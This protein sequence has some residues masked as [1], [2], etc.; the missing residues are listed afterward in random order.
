MLIKGLVFLVSME[1]NC[2]FS[3]FKLISW[4]VRGLGRPEKRR[5]IAKLVR[6]EKPSMVLIQESKLE[7]VG[8]SLLTQIGGGKLNK[9]EFSRSVGASGGLVSV[10]EDSFFELA[11]VVL[12]SRFVLLIGK[13]TE[14]NFDCAICNLYAPNVDGDR[15]VLWEKLLNLKLQWDVPWC[16]GGD[17]NAVRYETERRGG[18]FNVRAS[19]N[20]EFFIQSGEFVD[21]NLNGRLFT[22]SNNRAEASMARL[23]RFLISLDWI[24]KVPDMKQWS[25]QKGLS[26]HCPIVLGVESIDW[27]PTPFRF[28]NKWLEDA[29]LMEVMDG[30]W[31]FEPG[32]LNAGFR[33]KKK[34]QY[35]KGVLKRKVKEK[36]EEGTNTVSLGAQI[37]SLDLKEELQ[38]LDEEERL[39]RNRLRAELWKT[40]RFEEISWR[41]KSR[42]KWLKEGDKNTAFFHSIAMSRKRSNFLGFL[43]FNG[44]VLKEPRAIREEVKNHFK[45]HYESMGQCFFSMDNYVF[46][47]LDPETARD[48]ESDFSEEE[49]LGALE[50]CNEDRA[51]GPDGFNFGFI[52]KRWRVIKQDIMD[53]LNDFCMSGKLAKG[54]NASFIALIP[55]IQAPTVLGD[56][57]PI[58]LIGC[59]YKLLAKILANRLRSVANILVNPQQSAFV[60]GKNILDSI[61]V[62]SEVVHSMR[63]SRRGGFLFKVDFEKAYDSVNWDFLM[64][65]M[66]KM[67]FG[68]KWRGWIYECISTVTLS[69][70]VNGSPTEEFN[71]SRGL[72]QGDPLSPLLFNLVATGLSLLISKATSMDLLK[73][74]PVAEGGIAITHLQYADDTLLFCE[75]QWEQ[76][77]TFKRIL[78]CFELT[79]G[80]RMNLFKSVLIG[81]NFDDTTVGDWAVRLKCKHGSFPIKYLGFPLAANPNRV[82]TWTPMIESI[83]RKLSSWK[84]KTLSIGGRLALI[85]SVLNNMPVY[86][87]SFFLIPKS[88][89]LAI[90]RLQRQFLWGGYEDKKK[91]SWV[92]WC[93]VQNSKSKGGLGV[94]NILD[95]NRALIAKWI[96]RFGREQ[97]QLLWKDVLS[98]KYDINPES[99]IMKIRNSRSLSPFAKSLQSL[100]LGTE[101][102]STM[103]R[104]GFR[105]IIGN[106]SFIDFWEDPWVKDGSLKNLYPRIFALAQQKTGSINKFGEW[107]GGSWVWNILLRRR[108]FDWEI[109][110]WNEF[111]GLISKSVLRQASNDQVC[112]RFENNGIFMI[113]SFCLELE[114]RRGWSQFSHH[115]IWGHGAPPKVEMFGWQVLQGRV[116]VK[117]NLHSI[118]CLPQGELAC[119]FCKG[120]I[121]SVDHLFLG[122]IKSWQIWCLCLRIWD[123]KASLPKSLSEL[124]IQWDGL[125]PSLE[126]GKGWKLFFF[127]IIWSLW[128]TRNQMVFASS[129]VNWSEV[130]EIIKFRVICWFKNK[131]T[132]VC[133]S[134][135][136]MMLNIQSAISLA[137]PGKTRVLAAWEVPPIGFLKFNVDGSAH[138]KPGPTGIGGVLRDHDG[139]T[140]FL[141]AKSIGVNDSNYA[142]L[143]AIQEALEWFLSADWCKDF[144]LIIESDSKVAIKWVSSLECRCWKYAESYNKIRNMVDSI[145]VSKSVTFNHISRE[146]NY[147]A[148]HLAKSGVYRDVPFF[149]WL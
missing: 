131:S 49:I 147:F 48:L 18:P 15:A 47:R 93:K 33:I 11:H 99:L 22:W 139:N 68:V 70:L 79:S 24:Q 118:G 72:R 26:D 107:I 82:T 21:L 78:T 34:L 105:M 46:S 73:G 140:R 60:K 145:V 5:A 12:D 83:R 119:N 52:K 143:R 84:Q 137:K 20:L 67:G 39:E 75:A 122:C 6:M 44:R 76:L 121:E 114:N 127:A 59:I 116:A 96:W 54:L 32:P 65:V 86:L 89:A 141:F 108:V 61:L 112:W 135:N 51:P 111:W 134:I 63:N 130:F 126:L 35:T 27:G 103:T 17:F 42:I 40:V 13:I 149:A 37:N 30:A 28:Y 77:A 104:E 64:V 88:V 23:D 102:H 31:K 138:G 124:W 110:Q 14:L 113:K 7:E 3:M 125:R 129:M 62:A 55:K 85:K 115:N 9:L 92:A 57:R 106:G 4:N 50:E 80:L 144:H 87:M 81:V 53:F 91:I 43:N 142:E 146:I 8:G 69:V 90:E 29:D 71:M 45:D 94:G 38:D 41:Q 56:F 98:N 2:S 58:S 132:E 10:W 136:D 74:I 133:M 101:L 95:K 123:I 100:L 36:M 109:R 117:T 66:D 120:E 148:D 97:S 25:L 1:I 16:V 19:R 128:L